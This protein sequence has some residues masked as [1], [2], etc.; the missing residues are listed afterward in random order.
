MDEHEANQHKK[1]LDA[2]NE[3]KFF[4]PMTDNMESKRGE[5]LK[6]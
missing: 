6:I 5:R 3:D 4:L 1:L 2:L